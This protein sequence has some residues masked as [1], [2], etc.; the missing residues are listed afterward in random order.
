MPSWL[1]PFCRSSLGASTAVRHAS[2]PLCTPCDRLSFFEYRFAQC[3]RVFLGATPSLKIRGILSS[4]NLFFQEISKALAILKH[5]IEWSSPGSISMGSAFEKGKELLLIAVDHPDVFLQKASAFLEEAKR[6][7][8]PRFLISQGLLPQNSVGSLVDYGLFPLNAPE[9]AL[10]GAI[11]VSSQDR[12]MNALRALREQT[13]PVLSSRHA[14][15]FLKKKAFQNTQPDASQKIV[16]Y[17]CE[18]EGASHGF[19]FPSGMSAVTALFST[20]R[21]AQ[22]SHMIAFGH[23]YADTYHLLHDATLRYVSP[24]TTFLGTTEVDQLPQSITTQTAAIITESI[25]NPLNDVPDLEKIGRWTQQF[26]VPFVVD[27]TVAT[28][29]NCKPMNYGADYVIHSSTKY[30]SGQ[31]DH[32]GGVLLVRDPKDAAIIQHLQSAWKN[33]LSPWECEVLWDH[34]QDFESRMQRFNQNALEVVSF[35]EKHPAV[36][37]VYF[38]SLP[39]H[40]SYDI[41]QKILTGHSSVVSFTLKQSTKEAFERFYD[42]PLHDIHK[43]ASLGSNQTLMCPYTLLAHYYETD[44]MLE[45]LHLPRYLVRLAIGCELNINP[46]LKSLNDALDLFI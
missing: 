45:E 35:L 29:V 24:Q 40:Q 33:H 3:V 38:S 25:T 2:L 44:S 11:L 43:A 31:N 23:L 28:F 15:Y 6:Q 27:N 39:S 18:K 37:H 21:S 34:V 30:F 13:G 22:R 41:A 26:G 4:E 5:P 17:L 8:I 19:L 46:V 16:S 1:L 14:A 20:L 12:Q 10:E 7:R 42:A 32:A 9:D 36:Q